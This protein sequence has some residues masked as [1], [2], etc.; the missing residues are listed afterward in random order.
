MAVKFT[1][2]KTGKSITLKKKPKNK[3]YKKINRKNLA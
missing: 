3:V 2:K 1:N